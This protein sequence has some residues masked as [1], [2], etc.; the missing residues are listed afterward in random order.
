MTFSVGYNKFN[1]NNVVFVQNVLLLQ[2]YEY[3]TPP[4]ML[5]LW[6]SREYAF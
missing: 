2:R 3:I 6:N 1:A 4:I 5:R